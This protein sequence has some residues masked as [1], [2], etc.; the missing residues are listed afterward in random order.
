MKISKLR[1]DGGGAYEEL[2]N[3]RHPPKKT[4]NSFS[5]VS[6]SGWD[7]ERSP[8]IEFLMWFKKNRG[9]SDVWASRTVHFTTFHV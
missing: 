9:Q 6:L 1:Y 4:V 5:S 3:K 7:L 2:P 8:G